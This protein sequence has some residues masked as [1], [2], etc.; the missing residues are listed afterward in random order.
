[1]AFQR[2][3][4]LEVSGTVEARTRAA[5]EPQRGSGLR[6]IL[7]RG[8]CE[9]SVVV[10]QKLL[11]T[12]GFD[13]GAKDG[14]FGPKTERAVLAFQRTKGL[15]ADGVVGPNTWNA[16]GMTAPRA[17]PAAVQPLAPISRAEGGRTYSA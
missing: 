13:P 15:E 9:A 8:V 10:L 4:G 7:K 2:A 6:P 5:L 11:A 3:R 12:H 17:F 16:L 1:M 14:L